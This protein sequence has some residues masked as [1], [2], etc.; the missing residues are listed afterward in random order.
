MISE[1][2]RAALVGRIIAGILATIGGEHATDAQIIRRAFGLAD[3]V[4]ARLDE[5]RDAKWRA[6]SQGST[7]TGDPLHHMN[8]SESGP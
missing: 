8:A 6:I 2:D 7:L 1:S 3:L 5:E 4:A